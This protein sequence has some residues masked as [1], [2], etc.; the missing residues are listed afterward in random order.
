MKIKCAGCD[1][2]LTVEGCYDD[3]TWYCESCYWK[4]KES[5]ELK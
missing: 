2:Q 3:L 1:K 5:K 4:M